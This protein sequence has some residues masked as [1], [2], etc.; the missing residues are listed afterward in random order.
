MRTPWLFQHYRF[1][2]FV[3]SLCLKHVW[4]D[5]NYIS[6]Q[7]LFF[8]FFYIINMKAQDILQAVAFFTLFLHIFQRN[9]R[10]MIPMKRILELAP[11]VSPKPRWCGTSL[12]HLNHTCGSLCILE[13]RYDMIFSLFLDIPLVPVPF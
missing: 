4:E 10:T 12:H 7:C 2:L 5:H 6:F 9:N 8:F 11:S 1:K 13:W 3:P